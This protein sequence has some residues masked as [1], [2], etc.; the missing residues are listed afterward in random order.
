MHYVSGR[1]IWKLICS[2]RRRQIGTKPLK[3]LD[4]F[5]IFATTMTSQGPRQ[6]KLIAGVLAD[7]ARLSGE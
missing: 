3:K 5:A 7:F 1:R 2:Q 6:Q 4:I